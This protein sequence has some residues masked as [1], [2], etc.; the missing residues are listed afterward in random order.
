MPVIAVPPV[1]LCP[2]IGYPTIVPYAVVRLTFTLPACRVSREAP[3][4]QWPIYGVRIQ[5]L[6]FYASRCRRC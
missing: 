6:A 4:G 2:I 3:R 1:G 5:T